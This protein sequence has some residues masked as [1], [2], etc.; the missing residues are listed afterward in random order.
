MW[1]AVRETYNYLFVRTGDEEAT[2][3]VADMGRA[4]N[5]TRVSDKCPQP[6]QFG[7]STT[8]EPVERYLLDL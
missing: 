8:R 4:L 1:L 6:V 5:K 7:T 2:D 3:R